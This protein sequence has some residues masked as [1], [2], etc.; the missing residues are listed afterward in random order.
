MSRLRQWLNQL[1]LSLFGDD[2]HTSPS[3]P[4]PLNQT[5]LVKPSPRPSPTFPTSPTQPLAKKPSQ[6]AARPAN[7]RVAQL[8]SH[9]VPY[10]I[11]RVRR[12]TVGL[13]VDGSGLRVRASHAVTLADIER[14]V[15]GK[16]DW[17]LRNL[18]K[19]QNAAPARS[20]VPDLNV[21]EGDVLP[22]LG[23]QVQVRWSTQA[24][25]KIDA[26]Q[27][28]AQQLTAEHPILELPDVVPAKREQTVVDALTAI[29]LAYLCQQARHYA[30]THHLRYRVI[31]LSNAKT[32][33]GTCRSDGTLRLNWRLVFLDTTLVDYVLA[34]ELSHTVHMNHSRLFWHQVAQLCPDYKERVK[35]LKQYNLRAV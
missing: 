23:R 10:T 3:Q 4:K 31:V 19:M 15:Q 28:C 32:L 14:I 20:F 1:Q 26:D 34:H 13:L 9:Q 17:I 18:H 2:E 12:R 22:I 29:V 5:R 7:V 16:A 8:G 27:W 35:R 11:E 24:A 21:N 33:W 25:K 6:P 30:Q